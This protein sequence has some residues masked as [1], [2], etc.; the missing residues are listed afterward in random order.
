MSQGRA[1]PQ[2]VCNSIEYR[3][4]SHPEHQLWVS[5][6]LVSP[7]GVSNEGQGWP[8]FSQTSPCA[9]DMFAIESELLM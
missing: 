3:R 9:V 7:L 1:L 4:A 8:R 5:V 2:E 6:A